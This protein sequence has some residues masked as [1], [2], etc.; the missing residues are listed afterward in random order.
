MKYTNF[1]PLFCFISKIEK[2]TVSLEVRTPEI[3]TPNWGDNFI[4]YY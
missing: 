4:I 1:L 2:Q 3:E